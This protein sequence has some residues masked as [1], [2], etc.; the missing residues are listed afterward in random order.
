MI[1][2]RYTAHNVGKVS[3]CFLRLSPYSSLIFSISPSFE[4][5]ISSWRNISWQI[6]PCN[7]YS[8]VKSSDLK[9]SAV[10]EDILPKN[11]CFVLLYICSL[12]YILVAFNHRLLS[13]KR[14]CRVCVCLTQGHCLLFH[15]SGFL[16]G[17]WLIHI[18]S[19]S[20]PNLVV[21]DIKGKDLFLVSLCQL[22][23]TISASPSC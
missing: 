15:D 17:Q 14:V 3:Y 4:P 8:P 7:L 6:L 2:T 5:D 10:K 12:V 22:W 19:L 16:C 9:R 1:R 18:Q 23:S 21:A 20:H 13:Y 11:S